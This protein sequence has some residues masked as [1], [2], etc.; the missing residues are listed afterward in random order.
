MRVG[1]RPS[2][3]NRWRYLVTASTDL[4]GAEH[5]VAGQA[6]LSRS[7]SSTLI[8]QTIDRAAT[9]GGAGN[10]FTKKLGCRHSA[11]FR[12]NLDSHRSNAGTKFLDLLT[13]AVLKD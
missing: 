13:V 2:G 9:N 5:V 1:Y 8:T 3:N 7:R 6:T 4:T 11:E 10:D 12:I